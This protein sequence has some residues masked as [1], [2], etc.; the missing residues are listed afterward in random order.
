MVTQ[1][2]SRLF[3]PC[4][5]IYPLKPDFYVGSRPGGY[6][7]D[8]GFLVA[9]FRQHPEPGCGSLEILLV[10]VDSESRVLGY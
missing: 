9:N 10:F 1:C 4:T 6:S 3:G 2:A 5:L 8:F 7:G